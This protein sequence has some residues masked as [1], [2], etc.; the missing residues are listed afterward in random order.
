VNTFSDKVLYKEWTALSL[1]AKMV[2]R[3]VPYYVTWKLLN[4]RNWPTPWKHQFS[5]DFRS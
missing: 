1:G 5:T 4:A 2:R 3:D